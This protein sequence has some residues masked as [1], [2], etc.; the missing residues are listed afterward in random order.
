MVNPRNA[1]PHR[2]PPPS[3]PRYEASSTSR[4]AHKPSAGA[5]AV[6]INLPY[7]KAFERLFL[8][9]IVGLCTL[10]L[11]PKATLEIPSGRGRLSRIPDLIGNCRYLIH[12]LS[13]VPLA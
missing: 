4:S 3:V 1:G 13:R 5:K 7:D 11:Q 9:Y 12:D 6:F 2:E 8:A 10:G